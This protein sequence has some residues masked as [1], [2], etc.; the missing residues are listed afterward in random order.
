MKKATI[1][2][3]SYN[4]ESFITD[5]LT[6]VF[7]AD[8][9]SNSEVIVWDNAS[10]DTTVSKIKKN[11]P[12]VI[13]HESANNI[14]FAAAINRVALMASGKY[15]VLLN[16]DTQVEKRWLTTLLETLSKDGKVAAVNSK[17]KILNNGKEYIQNAGSYLFDDGHARDRGAVVT[18]SKEQL[19]ELD[20]KYYSLPKEV[21]A[22]CGAST[23]LNKEVFLDLGGFDE[24]MFL[25][26]EDTDLSIRLRKRGYTI[27][28]QPKSELTHIHTASSHEWSD[29]FIYH[30]EL[31]RLLL[32][33]K[34]F[35]IQTILK[36]TLVYKFSIVYQLIKL[37]KRFLTR[38]KVLFS[39]VLK[40]PYLLKFRMEG[41]V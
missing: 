20:S 36:E 26:Y 2:L 25:Y 14:G 39:L 37:N 10:S 16:P 18:D 33:W 12:D 9:I 31:N 23:A 34:H 13:L 40:M 17:I 38:M 27:L 24:Q 29:F 4:S 11:F 35:P 21:D 32:L 15:L 28:Y 8:D 19:Y 7:K 5:C 1:I 30:T 41:N 6:S 3:I 22:F